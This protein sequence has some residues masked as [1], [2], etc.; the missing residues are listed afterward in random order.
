MSNTNDNTITNDN[1]TGPNAL[2]ISR[3]CTLVGLSIRSFGGN[4]K[5][6]GTSAEVA[7][8][9]GADD[10]RVAVY[11]SVL[12]KDV[13]KPIQQKAGEARRY[14]DSQT[15]PWDTGLRLLPNVRRDAVVA[16]LSDFQ[17]EYFELVKENI[18]DRYDDL[19]RAASAGLGS[20]FAKVGFPTREQ[21]TAK[22]EFDIKV[23]LA[24]S[25][26]DIRLNHVSP[27]ARLEIENAIAKQNAARVQ[28]AH[29]HVV[30]TITE[31]LE[32]ICTKLPKFEDGEIKRFEDSLLGNLA[33]AVE[34]LPSLN[35][36]G[37][38][39]VAEAIAKAR[40]IVAKA[41]LPVL[42][43]KA[44]PEAKA[45]RKEVVKAA[46]DILAAL[47]SGAVSGSIK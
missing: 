19:A 21:I 40:G 30:R 22:Y 44:K 34:V 4:V 35:V 23:D 5:D 27:K 31:A 2:D 33:D 14:L 29:E 45:H 3:D 46:G 17:R 38:P 13:R 24:P 47:K 39:A 20:L 26:S 12:P 25:P 8:D 28:V 6:K 43:D 11:L 10:D 15:C 32:A 18:L 16:R 1:N 41:Q 42:R 9:N 36:T 37:D 7:S